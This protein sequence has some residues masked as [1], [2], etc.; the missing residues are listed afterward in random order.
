MD[1]SLSFHIATWI[2]IVT[3]VAGV[4]GAMI[5][6]LRS[7][8]DRLLEV[9]VILGIGLGASGLSTLAVAVTGRPLGALYLW[10]ATALIGLLIGPVIMLRMG[11]RRGPPG[12]IMRRHEVL[13][14]AGGRGGPP[15]IEPEVARHG[16]LWWSTIIATGIMASMAWLSFQSQ[17]PVIGSDTPSSSAPAEAASMLTVAS[18]L[19][20]AT[21]VALAFGTTY[22]LFLFVRLLEQ[23]GPPEIETHWGGI[24]GGLGG[25]RMSRS[26]GYLLV[27]M[28]LAA[29]FSFFLLRFD[30]T[31]RTERPSE[32]AGAMTP[33]PN[34][35]PGAAQASKGA[36][37]W[38]ERA[39]LPL[40][41]LA[42]AT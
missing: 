22:F 20:M 19:W 41:P 21:L 28:V 39:Q 15:G 9:T 8:S 13:G 32:K 37:D 33:L 14:S 23:G 6:A 10:R 25:W 2:W 38:M 11:G 18:T 26:L 31:G 7:D 4:T 24:G 3:G 17:P 40:S 16:S 30:A 36:D 35:N 27:A 5:W 42:S 34:A 29:L 12:N 1:P